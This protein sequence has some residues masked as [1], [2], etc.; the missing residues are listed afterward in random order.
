M[1][2][3]ER[4]EA[5]RDYAFDELS[6]AERL[7]LER[8]IESCSACEADLRSVQLTAAVLQSVPDREIPQRIAFVSDKLFEP[9]PWARFWRG[10]FGSPMQVG[11]ASACLLA[12]AISFSATRRPAEIRTVVTAQGSAPVDVSAQIDLAVKKAVAQVHEEDQRQTQIALAAAEVRHKQEHDAL[13][14]SMRETVDVMQRRMGAYTSEL[15]SLER[16][17][18]GGGQ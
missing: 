2:T 18:M 6:G 8:H 12:A 1:N 10:F 14:V 13:L 9:S 4:S 15:A 3:C 11:F 16:P 17:A 5:L 7:A